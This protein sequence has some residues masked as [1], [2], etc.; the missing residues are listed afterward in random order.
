VDSQNSFGAMLRTRF[1][2]AIDP[3]GKLVD[4]SMAD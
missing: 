2:C 3:Q 4:I 1:A